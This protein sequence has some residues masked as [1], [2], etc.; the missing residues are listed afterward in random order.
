MAKQVEF[1]RTVI[2][3]DSVG[4]RIDIVQQIVKIP[5]HTSRRRAVT[6]ASAFHPI[7]GVAKAGDVA[8][9]LGKPGRMAFQSMQHDD[10]RAGVFLAI[11]QDSYWPL[12][13]AVQEK[14]VRSI[15]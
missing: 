1:P 5:A 12:A 11:G 6:G 8:G 3:Q 10:R 13:S 4:K 14:R 2:G 9:G 7:N 15:H